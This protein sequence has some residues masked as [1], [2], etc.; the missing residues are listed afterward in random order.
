VAFWLAFNEC[1]LTSEFLAKASLLCKKLDPTRLVSGA[2][3]ANL[4]TTKQ[5]F[6]QKGFDFYTFHPYGPQ[7]DS[8]TAG[9][10]AREN[11]TSITKVLAF[12]DDKPVFFTE[13]GGWYVINNPAL[14]SQF[15]DTMIAAGKSQ[16]H[17][18]IL[19]GMTY[20]VWADMYE[21][22][23]GLPACHAG[24][25][26]EG[27]VD[28]DRDPRVN[29]DIFTRKLTQMYIEPDKQPQVEVYRLQARQAIY[30]PIDIMAGQDPG[31]MKEIWERTLK[32]TENARG[33]RKKKFRL[34][35]GPQ[36]PDD[37]FYIGEMP[38]QLKK[39]IPVILNK[40]SGPPSIPVQAAASAIHFIGQAGLVRGYP[41][42]GKHGEVVAKY[43]IEFDDDT[44]FE[45]LLRNGM[46]IATVM[47]LVGPSRIDPRASAAPRI[48]KITYDQD[49]E[50]Y[51]LNILR[52]QLPEPKM[53]R[54][55][56]TEIEDDQY[57]LLIYGITLES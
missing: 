12:L 41:F 7:I 6:N 27:L 3:C 18:T 54:S 43:I 36:L 24:I 20:W 50:E 34:M 30:T 22:N 38:V 19:A 4:E 44:E 42:Y 9:Y 31:K 16:K 23:R 45:V 25:L 5:L 28:V 11:T 57:K 53:I 35:H 47:G 40:L 29:L 46:E 49:W 8:V 39:G 17:G 2:N 15:L 1:I 48:M 37:Y 26:N 32:E 33:D 52:V 56:R 55:I 14:F 10:G 51:Y 13:W 21:T